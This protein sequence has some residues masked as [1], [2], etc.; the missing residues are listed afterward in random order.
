MRDLN[1]WAVRNY[2]HREVQCK[3]GCGISNMHSSTMWKFQK[4]RDYAGRPIYGN[5]WCRCPDHN[6]KV[7]GKPDSSHIVTEEKPARA[8]D[9]TFVN[10]KKP[11]PMTGGELYLLQ[12]ALQEAGFRRLGIS[13]WFIHADDDPAKPAEVMWLY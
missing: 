6:E 8:G 2:S 10:P 4:A 3:C 9:V 5:S 13:E 12:K 7:G 11:R 1:Q